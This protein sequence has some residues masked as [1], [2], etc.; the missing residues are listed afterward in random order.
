VAVEGP[1]LVR[2]SGGKYTTYRLMARDAIDAVLGD[3]A[4]DRPSGTATMRITGAA[5]MTDLHALTA[6]LAQEPGVGATA[7][8]S[9]VER[10]GTAAPDVLARGRELDLVRPLVDGHPFLE[11]E[12]AWAAERELAM[13]LDDV[14]ARRMRLAMTLRD[15]GASIAP[16]VAAITGQVLG[17][18]GTRRE[19]EAARY[20]E[21]ARREFDVPPPA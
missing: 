16:R 6:R 12:V 18:D 11:A 15:R 20:L 19:T 8:Q 4:R 2:I 17:W 21:G 5:P 14:L 10:H 9:L 3:G 7:A 1:G 13:S